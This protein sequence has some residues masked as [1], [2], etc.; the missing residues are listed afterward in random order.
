MT[1]AEADDGYV[2][3]V[4]T[5]LRHRMLNGVLNVGRWKTSNGY[6]SSVISELNVVWNHDCHDYGYV[7]SLDKVSMVDRHRH[8]HRGNCESF[9]MS[10]CRRRWI[11]LFCLHSLLMIGMII[12][13][14][15]IIIVFSSSKRGK[16][17]QIRIKNN[18]V[19]SA[20]GHSSWNK[21]KTN[22]E[23]WRIEKN[24]QRRVKRDAQCLE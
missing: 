22:E 1:K 19:R 15:I 6:C 16:R 3:F 20:H 13:I 4:V 11:V 5:W 2:L 21:T 8:R 23:R 7:W 17:N 24:E 9:V 10:A 18:K 14:F 12:F